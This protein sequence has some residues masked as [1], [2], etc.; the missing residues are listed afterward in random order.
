MILSCPSCQTR[1]VVPDSAIGASGRQVRCAQCR[2]SWFQEPPESRAEAPRQP[3][4]GFPG[5]PP[6]RAA[7]PPPAQAEPDPDGYDPFAPEPPFRPRRNPARMWTILAVAAALLMIAAAA[8]IHY[9]G[10]PGLGAQRAGGTPLRLE[11]MTIQRRTLE[12]GNILLL[13]S[14]RITNR[15]EDPQ[16]VPPIQAEMKDRQG[17]V[18]Y[19]WTIAPPVS[20]LSP[21]QTA[22]FNSAETGVPTT[23]GSISLDFATAG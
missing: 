19:A 16:P 6:Q 9:F 18:V 4:P 1:Y 22:T 21:G 20:E 12:S 2:H 17:R 10:I 8:G 23:A 7:P 14:G 11:A 13:V 3:A 15:A 5:P